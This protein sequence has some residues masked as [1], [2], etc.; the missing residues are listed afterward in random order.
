[1]TVFLTEHIDTFIFGGYVEI[2][3]SP[4]ITVLTENYIFFH[5]ALLSFICLYV[6]EASI[7]ELTSDTYLYNQRKI[8]LLFQIR[9]TLLTGILYFADAILNAVP[10]L[11]PENISF[12][13]KDIISRIRVT[14]LFDEPCDLTLN[15]LIL[16]P[17]V[18]K[19]GIYI[20]FLADTG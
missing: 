3:N 11:T 9:C 19:M 20:R 7:G 8:L 17:P 6:S 10:L 2:D 16:I 14:L 12:K 15:F 1:M 13:I 18:K 5:I 4:C